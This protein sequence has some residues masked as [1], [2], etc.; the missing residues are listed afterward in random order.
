M[1]LKQREWSLEK[2]PCFGMVLCFKIITILSL[3]LNERDYV[4]PLSWFKVNLKEVV[5]ALC[6][7]TQF[8]AEMCF[9][10]TIISS[11]VALCIT[12]QLWEFHLSQ[13]LQSLIGSFQIIGDDSDFVRLFFVISWLFCLTKRKNQILKQLSL[14]LILLFELLNS[15]FCLCCWFLNVFEISFIKRVEIILLKWRKEQKY[16]NFHISWEFDLESVCES[17]IL[18]D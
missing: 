6:G 9:R 4:N 11:K 13:T 1:G 2:M 16:Q 17:K 15:P 3:P 18:S 14:T 7:M 12:T 10:I 8:T 5:V